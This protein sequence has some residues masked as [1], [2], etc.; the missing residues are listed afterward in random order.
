MNK[1]PVF[2]VGLN[3]TGST[4]LRNMLD[5][6][7]SLAMIPE[8]LHLWDPYPWANC[9]LSYCK[10][11]DLSKKENRIIFLNLLFSKIFYG[12]FWEKI[13][14]YNIDKQ[15]IID[16]LEK[17]EDNEL[18]YID[19]INLL[20]NYYLEI[21]K[22]DRFGV[23]YPLHIS[24]IDLLNKWYPDCKIIHLTRDLRAIYL[25]KKNDEFSTKI[26]EKYKRL[27]FFIDF[28][29]F[30][31]EIAEYNWSRRIHI[32]Y[33]KQD[34]YLLLNFEKLV[35]KPKETILDICK[36]LEIPFEE[37]MLCPK[38]KPSSFT[39]KISNRF[40]IDR[41]NAWEKKIK[42]WERKLINIFASRSL[43]EFGYRDEY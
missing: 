18:N 31:R 21:R 20:F 2:I 32:I 23:K 38:G 15:K 8:E 14:S 26:K 22:K 9:V 39:K 5:L 12:S 30:V 1:K 11:K 25:S 28:F 7:S 41:I 27:N 24:R 42:P 33:N 13:D 10:N 36:F 17:I 29:I 35:T 6:N 43:R 40:D 34:N 4:L 37:Q 16:E 19:I 3:R